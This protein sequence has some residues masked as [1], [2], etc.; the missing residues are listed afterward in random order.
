METLTTGTS[1]EA[2]NYR[3]RYISCKR[4]QPLLTAK[5]AL[6]K[7]ILAARRNHSNLIR[8]SHIHTQN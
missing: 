4:L 6:L 5:H 3:L 1:D 8:N 2:L 7:L